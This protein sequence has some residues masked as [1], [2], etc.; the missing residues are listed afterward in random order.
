M[1]DLEIVNLVP[2]FLKFFDY[3]NH[4]QVDEAKRWQLWKEHYNFAALPPGYDE[5]AR[6]Q[7]N[8]S[9]ENYLSQIGRIR[10]W[11]PEQM[12]VGKFYEEV[13]TLLGSEEDIPFVVVFFVGSFDS[14]AFV[15]PYNEHKS[16]LCLPVETRL[17]DIIIAHELTHIVHAE[18]AS[19]DMNW[20]RPVAE[21]IL[22]EGLAL[23]AS[24]Y[25]IPG[26][27][28]EA[29]IEM[30]ERGW[31][32]EC[33]MDRTGI[34]EG[35]SAYLFDSSSEAVEKFT[36]GTGAFG[37]R[38]EAYYAGWEFVGSQL[39]KGVTFQQ[40]AAIQQGDIPDYIKNNLL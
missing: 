26:E 24:K 4:D 15:A 18:T 13:K 28:D 7:L 32:E 9:W 31:L 33:H 19:L 14:N 37:H 2:E 16:M 30:G 8:Q 17:P 5:A 1:K 35:I 10:D 29:Y 23:Q 21:L 39:D 40:L 20:E 27:Q 11:T 36:F 34:L 22:Q 6:K 38:R 12:E 25:L 3:A